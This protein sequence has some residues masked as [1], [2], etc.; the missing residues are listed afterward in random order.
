MNIYQNLEN[1]AEKFGHKPFA[2]FQRDEQQLTFVELHEAAEAYAAFLSQNGIKK[3]SRVSVYLDKS[4]LYLCVYFALLKLGAVVHTMD[5]KSNLKDEI[6]TVKILDS[7]RIVTIENLLETNSSDLEASG[8]PILILPEYH[9]L[10]REDYSPVLTATLEPNHPAVCIFTSG[11]TGV[12]K[13]VISSHKNLQVAAHCV[14]HSHELTQS[15]IALNTIPMSNINGQVTTIFGP[16][17]TGSS[18]VFYQ[19]MFLTAGIFSCIEKYRV[20]WY[21]GIPTQYSIMN[22]FQVAP[23]EFNISC[24][25]FMRS[26]SA[27]LPVSVQ[28]NFEKHYKVDIINTL[29]LTEMTGQVFANPRNRCEREIGS[30]GKPVGNKAKVIDPN[31]DVLGPNQV[32]EVIVSGE[33]LMLGY[34]NDVKSTQV[35][36]RNGW[37]Y[38]GDIG[39]YNENNFFFI[40]GRKKDIVIVG[41]M[42]VS[43]SE[44]DEA[45][46]TFPGVLKTASIG[47]GLSED[48]FGLGESIVSFV[49]KNPNVDFTEQNVHIHCCEILSKYKIPSKII[50]VESLPEGGTGKILRSKVKQM[51]EEI[52]P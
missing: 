12:P 40:V 19:D 11:T 25:K 29:G 18:V 44:V 49:V 28:E 50:F 46:Y 22:N 16:L 34:F 33:N 30:V 47:I 42:N 9:K 31:G 27:P 35:A 20:T 52:C 37:L 5:F 1:Q 13:G 10:R 45:I 2:I 23:D 39:Y 15:D 4:R 51:Y 41:G 8:K 21:S 17:L 43:L 32:G 14:I 36:I 6:K 3:Y 38:T 7:D 24:L 48:L 26:A